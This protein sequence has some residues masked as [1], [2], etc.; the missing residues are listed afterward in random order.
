MNYDKLIL[1]LTVIIAICI[2]ICIIKKVTK[3]IIFTLI[4]VFAFS[5]IKA[6]ESGKSPTEVFSASKH[7]V[8]YTKDIYDYTKKVKKSVENTL[9]G[10]ENK[11]VSEIIVENKN[12]HDYL[13]KVNK[14]PHGVELNVFH[15]KYYNYLKS[16]VLTSDTVVK[17][18]NISS[19]AIKNAE[20]AKTNLNKYL[21]D[22]LNVKEQ[23]L[24]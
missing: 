16:I 22:L 12:L 8:T 15:D 10:I 21:D 17:S 7:D 9:T 19:G 5:F 14:L 3:A 6:V 24:K 2:L 20:S 18:A 4:I 13:D 1:V 23:Y 11:S